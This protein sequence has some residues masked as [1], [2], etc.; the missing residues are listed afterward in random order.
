MSDDAKLVPAVARAVAILDLIAGEGR[1]LRLSEVA[2]RLGL[3]KSSAHGLC[4]TLVNL[5]LL[6]AHGDGFAIG[7]GALRWAGAF[8]GQFE[9]SRNFHDQAAVNG[10][11]ASYTVNL[12]VLDGTDIV[13][14]ACR[15]APSTLGITF[16]VGMRIP[17]AFPATGKAI[18]AALPDEE[19]AP[20]L[21]QLPAPLTSSGVRTPDALRAQIETIRACGYSIDAGEVRP[22]MTCFGA[23]VRD[24]LGRP[25]A[26][27]A[28]SMTSEEARS[29]LWSEAGARIA[30]LADCLSGL[31]R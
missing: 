8:D 29:S 22:G 27:V 18:L 23:A 13:Y 2:Q 15:N 20:F 28:L 26:G 16:R 7:P 12:S 5:R 19:L 14:V 30:R 11:L 1:P 4:Q 17:A 24:H 3:P 9:L 31:L 21:S 25:V 10:E 6:I